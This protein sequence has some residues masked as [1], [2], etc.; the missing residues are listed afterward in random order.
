M[1]GFSSFHPIGR[2]PEDIANY[3]VFLLPDKSNWTSAGPRA[4]I[5]MASFR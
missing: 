1:E 3:I 4:A 5:R 2:P